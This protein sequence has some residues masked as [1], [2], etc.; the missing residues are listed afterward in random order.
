MSQSAQ[1]L[2]NLNI[3]NDRDIDLNLVANHTHL[4]WNPVMLSLNCKLTREFVDDHPELPWDEKIV[5]SQLDRHNRVSL[6]SSISNR[7]NIPL[8]ELLTYQYDC[9]QLAITVIFHVINGSQGV[10]LAQFNNEFYYFCQLGIDGRE[11][12]VIADDKKT[13]ELPQLDQIHVDYL[14]KRLIK[15]LLKKVYNYA[16]DDDQTKRELESL[17][18]DILQLEIG[19]IDDEGHLNDY[20]RDVSSKLKLLPYSNNCH[21]KIIEWIC[22][23][24]HTS[25]VNYVIRAILKSL[26]DSSRRLCPM[27]LAYSLHAIIEFNYSIEQKMN[28][29]AQFISLTDIGKNQ[30]ITRDVVTSINNAFNHWREFNLESRYKFVRHMIKTISL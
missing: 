15:K 2:L 5:S 3:V 28:C 26:I 27:D 13:L 29:I 6:T 23:S 24:G 30:S 19:D 21:I 10:I 14:S 8:T 22:Q 1:E 4:P 20:K 9:G 7:P 11:L 17:V 12:S 25:Y 18:N 16:W